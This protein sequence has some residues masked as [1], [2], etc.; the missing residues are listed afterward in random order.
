MRPVPA[1]AR[2]RFRVVVAGAGIAGLEALLAL[3]ELAGDRVALTLLEPRAEL[4]LAAFEPAALLAGDAPLHVPIAT[5]AER[6]E[7]EVVRSPLERVDPDARTA[8]T[9]A[10]DAIGYD[11]LLVAVGARPS[12]G[13]RGALTWWPGADHAEF[14]RLTADAEEG[15]AGRIAF[16]V[17]SRYAWPLPAYELALLTARRLEEHGRR[18]DLLLVTPEPK[19]LAVVGPVGSAAVLA[20]LDAA[21]IAF[22]G[23]AVGA[24]RG[25]AQPAVEVWPRSRRFPVDRVVSLPRAWGPRV[26]GL[27]ADVEGFLFADELG[28]LRGT[29]GVWAIGDATHRLPRH[30]GLAALQADAAARDIAATAGALV[31]ARTYSPLLRAQLRTGLGRLWLQRDLS[32]P[33]D[34]GIAS[35]HALWAPPAKIAARRLGA[36]LAQP[37]APDGLRLSLAR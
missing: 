37:E 33:F 28:R 14:A 17:P 8:H 22:A 30:G 21:G 26:D 19:P 7:A 27:R 35:D 29:P 1:P 16:I 4:A 18:A 32:D 10:G 3:R 12:A 20:E 6:A 23:G 24:V 5:V 31:V 15:E 13:V 9:E 11:A 25:G 36:L 2:P 34:A